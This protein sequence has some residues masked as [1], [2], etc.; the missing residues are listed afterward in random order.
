M[1]GVLTADLA[2]LVDLDAVRVVLLVLH[3]G[4]IPALALGASQSDDI[5][6]QCSHPLESGVSF[7]GLLNKSITP[8]AGCQYFASLAALRSISRC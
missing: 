2:V 6:R 5:A 4:V 7:G 3:G 8:Y 1:E